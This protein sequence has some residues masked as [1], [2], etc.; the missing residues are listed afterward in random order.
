MS[1]YRVGVPRGWHGCSYHHNIAVTSCCL[2]SLAK[3]TIENYSCGHIKFITKCSALWSEYERA[4]FKQLCLV[5]LSP[6]LTALGIRLSIMQTITHAQLQ[7][8][9]MRNL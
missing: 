7:V 9:Q 4:D 8:K 2:D 3:T 5:L 1:S 6:P